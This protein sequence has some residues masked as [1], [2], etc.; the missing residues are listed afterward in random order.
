[1]CTRAEGLAGVSEGDQPRWCLPE[2]TGIEIERTQM[3]LE[4]DVEPLALR[5]TGLLGRNCDKRGANPS[6]PKMPG[7]HGVQNEGVCSTVPD[8]VDES[9]Q[10]AVFPRADPAETV[11]LK[12]CSPVGP[13][14]GG[15]EAVGVQGVEG[16]VI[17][18]ASALI[19]DRQARILV[20]RCG[21]GPNR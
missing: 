5:G 19:R 7:D 9:D 3:F 11:A 16:C 13:S 17:E 15:A 20:F 18:V 12:S 6:R 1:M 14:D 10:R 8:N 21:T 4:V 2:A